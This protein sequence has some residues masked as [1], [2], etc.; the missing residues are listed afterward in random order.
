MHIHIYTHEQRDLPIDIHRFRDS[1]PDATV[2][3][4]IIGITITKT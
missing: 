2:H 3:G 4:K 1:H